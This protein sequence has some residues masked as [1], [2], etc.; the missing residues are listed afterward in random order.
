MTDKEIK[1]LMAEKIRS[2]GGEVDERATFR[3]ISKAARQV[4]LGFARSGFERMAFLRILGMA[5]VAPP[6]PR[7][8]SEWKPAPHPRLADIQKAQPKLW[9]PGGIG[10]GMERVN[11]YGR[12]Q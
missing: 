1:R 11:G 4:G 3:D 8:H 7:R 10:N 2:L 12:G 9:T 6:E 5:P